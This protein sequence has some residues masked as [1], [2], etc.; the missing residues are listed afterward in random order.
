MNLNFLKFLFF[1]F[2]L[3]WQITFFDF[4]NLPK[5]EQK[6]TIIF[7]QNYGEA[8]A[9]DYYRMKFKLPHVVS[10][11]NSYWFWGYPDYADTNTVWIVIGSDTEDNYEYFSSVELAAKHYNKYGMPFENVDIFICRKP[12]MKIGEIWQKIKMF[13]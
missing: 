11:H 6:N 10:A 8:G 1:N 13:I 7:A 5:T 9:I 2:L 4:N 3:I 12:K